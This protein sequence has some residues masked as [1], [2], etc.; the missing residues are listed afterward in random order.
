MKHHALSILVILAMIVA[1]TCKRV[2]FYATDGATLI[3]STTKPFLKTGGERSLITVLGFSA[4]GDALH[5]H[6]LVIFQA[7][8][9]TVEPS[10]VEIMNGRAT[11]EFVSGQ[12]SGIAEIQARSGNVLAEPNPLTIAIGNAALESLSISATPAL[13]PPGGGQTK[14]RVVACDQNGN[15]LA[16]I[17]VILSTN[18]GYLSSGQSV[19]K[20]NGSGLVEDWLQTTATATVTAAS[21]DKTAEIEVRVEEEQENQLPSAT[22]SFSP[23]SPQKGETI[24][25]NGSLSTDSDGSIIRY[26]WDFGDGGTALGEKVQH[27]YTWEGTTNKTFTVVLKVTDN[28]GGQAAVTRD[29]TVTAI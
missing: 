21:G 12:Y 8:L 22:I 3:V 7:T 13:L 11:V 18:A 24:Y 23:A 15:L 27:Q 10:E 26:Q 14:I 29:V 28:K 9:G 19:Y 4:E 2:P 17:P 5:D 16:D 6:T 25:F 20:T 1:A